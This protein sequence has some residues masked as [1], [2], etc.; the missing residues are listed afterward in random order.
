MSKVFISYSH[1]DEAWKNRLVKHFKVLEME[2]LLNVWQDRAIKPGDDWLPEIERALETA[3]VAILLVSVD[4]LTSHFIRHK[5]IPKLLQRREE[6]GIRVIPLIVSPCAWDK[7]NW[8]SAL[9]GATR[10]NAELT[11][12]S[13]H[14]QEAAMARLVRQVHGLLE[15]N[16]DNP[17]KTKRLVVIDKLPTV[18]GEC[19]GRGKELQMLNNAFLNPDNDTRI[20]QFV[21]AGGTGKTKLLRYW[22]NKYGEQIPNRIIWSFYSQGTTDTKQVSISPLLNE[23]FKAFGVNQANYPTKEDKADAFADLMIQHK[24]LLV[25]DGLEPMQHG[26]RGMDGQLKDR[27]MSRLLKRLAVEPR[28]LCV[29]TT[30]I[31]VHDIADR[32]HILRH[33]LDNLSISDGIQL[34]QSYNIQSNPGALEAVVKKVGGHAL[35]LHLLGNAIATYLHGDLQK[36]D[37]LE[38]LVDGYGAQSLHASKVM[39]AYEKWLRDDTGQPLAELQLLYLLGLF[40]HPIET[41]VLQILWDAQIPQLTAGIPVKAWTTAIHALQ[42]K[43]HLL[44]QH[45]ERP[46]MLDCHPLIREYFGAQLK[47]RQASAWQQAHAILYQHYKTIPKQ[48]QP[49]TIDEMRPLFHAVAHGCAAGMHQQALDDVYRPRIRRKTEAYV[50]HQLGAFSD[51]LAVVAHFFDP[52]WHTPATGL[53]PESQANILGWAGFNLRALGRLREA[54][55]PMSASVKLCAGQE[56]WKTAAINACNLSEL[57]LTL[58]DV[59]SAIETAV[60]SVDYADNEGRAMPMVAN[61]T[62]QADALHQAGQLSEALDLFQA[63]EQIQQENLPR[64]PRLYSLQG[65]RYCDLLLAQGKTEDVLER[66]KESI[67]WETNMDGVPILNLALH[68]LTL[69]RAYMRQQEADKAIQWLD[70]AISRLHDASQQQYLPFG[71]LARAELY[72]YNQ[73]FDKAVQDLQEVHNIAKPNGMRLHLTDY[74]LESARL[75]FDMAQPK[76]V[77]QAHIEAATGLIK[78]TGYRRRMDELHTCVVKFTAA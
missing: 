5:E 77:I 22:L 36:L 25:L 33:T 21:A 17:D 6:E 13:E 68:R 72:R 3:D 74:H 49:D 66:A 15:T 30:R 31:E 46:D 27:T 70:Q 43:H 73:R 42:H 12:L 38:A 56:E 8:L 60:F 2:G 24:C 9:Q 28:A 52:P 64:Y 54:L 23:M 63:A 67:D 65:F 7:V 62:V 14:E 26:G 35:T 58:G 78:A 50:I 44:S 55:E 20:I 34:L 61:R 48:H 10:D 32:S 45:P 51:D 75:G 71:L 37:T 29:I 40:D 4:F 57:Q 69:G 41:D 53:T 18:L 11:S 59:E 19:F 47:Q 16:G 1:Q 76:G 39:Q